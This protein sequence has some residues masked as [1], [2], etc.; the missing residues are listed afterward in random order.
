MAMK[1]N[2]AVQEVDYARLRERLLED[3]HLLEWKAGLK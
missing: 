1:A 2:V 3:K